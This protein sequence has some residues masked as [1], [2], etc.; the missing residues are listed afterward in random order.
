M[1]SIEP[2]L[3]DAVEQQASDIYI[4]GGLPSKTA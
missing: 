2:L 1:F 4:I 3:R